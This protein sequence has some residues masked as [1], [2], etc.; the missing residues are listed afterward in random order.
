MKYSTRNVLDRDTYK[1]CGT[2]K[3]FWIRILIQI[4]EP[5]FRSWSGLPPK[6][7]WMVFE[8]RSASPKFC[9]NWFITCWDIRLKRRHTVS[10][11]GKESWKMIQDPRKNPGRHQYL[12]VSSPGHAL[13]KISSK[14]VHNS[15]CEILRRLLQVAKTENYPKWT[16]KPNPEEVCDHWPVLWLYAACKAVVKI[17]RKRKK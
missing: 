15:H 7:N 8:P 9:Q 1:P 4:Q 11:N 12:I 5:E 13:R 17:K 3:N 6:S 10:G 16:K 14:S 2:I